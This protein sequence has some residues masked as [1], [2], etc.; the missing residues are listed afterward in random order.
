MT[1]RDRVLGCPL[2]GALGDAWGGASENVPVALR[3]KFPTRPTLSDDSQL[4]PATCESIIECG[5]VDPDNIAS[6][7]LRWYR[8]GRIH[9]MGS[10]T[11]KAM[12]DLSVGTHWAV[13]GATGEYAAGNGVAMRVAPLAFVLDPNDSAHRVIFVTFA[14]SRT[15]VTRRISAGWRSG[16]LFTRYCRARGRRSKAFWQSYWKRCLVQQ[17]A[18]AFRRCCRCGFPLSMSRVSTAQPDTLWIRCLWPSIAR[19]RL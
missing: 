2:G 6:H 17:S 18:I 4:T 12:R 16:W 8:A 3:S 11:L 15:T 10:S 7:F 14:G 5:Q 9:G 13:A 19:R 1:L